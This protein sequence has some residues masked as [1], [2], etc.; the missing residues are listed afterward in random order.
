MSIGNIMCPDVSWD[1][2]PSTMFFHQQ[3][4]GSMGLVRG[5]GWGGVGVLG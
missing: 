4:H 1:T 3:L 5:G 2:V